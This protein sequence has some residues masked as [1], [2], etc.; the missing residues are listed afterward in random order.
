LT[1]MEGLFSAKALRREHWPLHSRSTYFL[2]AASCLTK[3]SV[4]RR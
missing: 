3:N 1:I 2:L 4:V